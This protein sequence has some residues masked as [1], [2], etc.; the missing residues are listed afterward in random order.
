LSRANRQRS[1]GREE[2]CIWRFANI[3]FDEAQWQLRMDGVAI[4]AEPRPLDLLQALLRHAGEVVEKNDLIE[5]VYG[6]SHIGD[7]ALTNA[8]GKLRRLLRD[9]DQQIV[10]TVHRIGYRFGVPVQKIV[11][12][13]HEIPAPASL[14]LRAGDTVPR[15]PHWQLLHPLDAR[16]DSEVWLAEHTKMR[17]RR[18]YKFSQTGSGLSALKR[19][20][21]LARVLLDGLGER[22]DFVH[23]LDWNFDEAPFF[24]E[25]D[26]AGLSLPEWCE[27]QGGIAALPLAQ[28]LELLARIAATV[29]AAHSVGVLHKDLKPLNVLIQDDGRGDLKVRVADF[30]S[31]RLLGDRRLRDLGIPE[32]GF[33]HTQS[34]ALFDQTEGAGSE[35]ALKLIQ[36]LLSIK[37]RLDKLDPVIP[38][39]E[40]TITAGEQ[41]LGQ[42]MQRWSKPSS[43]WCTPTAF[44]ARCSPPKIRCGT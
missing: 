26:Y 20:V 23:L 40:R 9:D 13:D 6:H 22:D 11:V 12:A 3:E 18:V 32:L 35:S 37:Y 16:A 8:V 29:V 39:V 21:T 2:A 7:G 28:R 5:A 34:M 41:R 38:Q 14:S 30:G 42:F 43:N 33:T 4:D 1:D 15:R 24:L 36:A 25:T 27:Q 10:V 17:E 19:E 44:A 31:G